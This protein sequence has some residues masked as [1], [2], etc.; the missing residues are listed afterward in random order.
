ME[1]ALIASITGQDG[2]PDDV[3]NLAVQSHVRVSFGEPEHTA[4]TAGTGTIRL[5]EAVRLPAVVS[6][7]LSWANLILIEFLRCAAAEH[8]VE[9]I[10]MPPTHV[11]E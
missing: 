7:T 9:E 6:L 10:C 2:A 3:Y 5:L 8:A 1:R 4:N 11:R